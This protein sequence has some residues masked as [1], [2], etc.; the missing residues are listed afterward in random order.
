MVV[1]I[2]C[3]PF[4]V[5]S[6]CLKFFIQLYVG[7]A[8]C[9]SYDPDQYDPSPKRE[10]VSYS[11]SRVSSTSRRSRGRDRSLSAP[12]PHRRKH[13]KNSHHNRLTTSDTQE[14]DQLLN[15]ATSSGEGR[16]PLLWQGREFAVGGHHITTTK[17]T[18]TTKTAHSS[19]GSV[20]LLPGSTHVTTIRNSTSYASHVPGYAEHGLVGVTASSSSS[21]GGTGQ[22]QSTS[23]GEDYFD[24]N[25][26]TVYDYDDQESDPE[27]A[28]GVQLLPE[29][30]MHPFE[31]T[32]S[33]G[34]AGT[35][36]SIL[37]DHVFN[38]NSLQ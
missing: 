35:V 23:Y 37:T 12:L 19:D 26:D 32:N 38:T 17:T 10:E 11:N 33:G 21:M 8:G 4:Y 25:V 6:F 5:C 30:H 7:Y 16:E 24:G 9:T 34:S 1:F 28:R 13:H 36:H 3:F 31:L 27:F 15:R 14:S 29:D 2:Y 22:S 18:K 20:R